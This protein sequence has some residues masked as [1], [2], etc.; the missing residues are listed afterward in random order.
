MPLPAE[1]S[2]VAYFSYD[3]APGSLYPDACEYLSSPSFLQNSDVRKCRNE[4]A[5]DI[6]TANAC[7]FSVANRNDACTIGQSTLAF[8]QSIQTNII[9]EFRVS[10]NV[11]YDSAKIAAV[12]AN[13]QAKYNA[14]AGCTAAYTT[15]VEQEILVKIRKIV[16]A[17][18]LTL[19][20]GEGDLLHQF[21]D[22]I[23]MGAQKKAILAPADTGETMENLM[24]SRHENGSSRSFELP[25]VGTY[26][27]DHQ[28]GAD[29]ESFLQKT[30]GSDTRIAVMAY[31]TRSI[32]DADNGGLHAFV[33]SLI[34]EKVQS[35]ITN[36]TN[37]QN[38]GC[39][40]RVTGMAWHWSAS[41]PLGAG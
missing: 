21:V 26:V 27:Y 25:C 1:F 32:V 4:N 17:L 24:Y 22:C 20:T 2:A 5:E 3:A 38:Y 29:T 12:N 35:I 30:C 23:F 31:I 36:I 33:A 40:G 16:D 6:A 28:D 8:E 34:T 19:T 13:V 15:D 37:V 10:N 9:D 7:G 41:V 18:D 39:L 11:L 14:V